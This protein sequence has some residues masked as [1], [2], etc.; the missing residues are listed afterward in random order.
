[1]LRPPAATIPRNGLCVPQSDLFLQAGAC[2][3]GTLARDA[4]SPSYSTGRS[5]CW[6]D[7]DQLHPFNVSQRE[8][9][10]SGQDP[11]VGS[12]GLACCY[13]AR[14]TLPRQKACWSQFLRASFWSPHA[15]SRTLS[16]C[17]GVLSRFLF[18]A[19]LLFWRN[20]SQFVR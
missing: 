15:E 1:M 4:T 7:E 9:T 12:R 5:T 18:S 11:T 14:A 10:A 20:S 17:F 19:F 6:G 3:M 2:F 16:C 8:G 13:M